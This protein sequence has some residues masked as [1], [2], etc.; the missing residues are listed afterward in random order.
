MTL[1]NLNTVQV[2]VFGEFNNCYVL[3]VWR[4]RLSSWP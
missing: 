1:E 4:L 2:S 3:K